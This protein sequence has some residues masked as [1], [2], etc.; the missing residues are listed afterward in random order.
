MLSAIDPAFDTGGST[1]LPAPA[2]GDIG[3]ALLL[4]QS[5][6]DLIVVR[7]EQKDTQIFNEP[8]ASSAEPTISRFTPDGALDPTFGDN[9]SVTLSYDGFEVTA[10][11]VDAQDRIVLGSSGSLIR[12]SPNGTPDD[13]FGPDGILSLPEPPYVLYSFTAVLPVQLAA[14]SDGTLLAEVET[15][16]GDG[17]FATQLIEIPAGGASSSGTRLLLTTPTPISNFT[18]LPDGSVLTATAGDDGNSPIALNDLNLN[19][20]PVTS[21]G[22]GGTAAVGIADDAVP[23]LVPEPDGD[24]LM[25]SSDTSASITNLAASNTFHLVRLTPAGNLDPAFDGGGVLSFTAHAAAL[26]V[27]SD[28]RVL[29]ATSGSGTSTDTTLAVTLHAFTSTGTPDPGVGGGTGSYSTLCGAGDVLGGVLLTAT[30]Q[31]VLLLGETNS[32]NGGYPNFSP[33]VTQA[34]TLV[35]LLA[36]GATP[37]AVPPTFTFNG[38]SPPAWGAPDL[39]FRVTYTASTA[40]S[41]ASVLHTTLSTAYLDPE[42][43]VPISASSATDAPSITVTYAVRTITGTWDTQDNGTYYITYAGGADSVADVDGNVLAMPDV[44][45]VSGEVGVLKLHAPKPKPLPVSDGGS[46]A[47]GS[48]G[49]VTGINDGGDLPPVYEADGGVLAFNDGIAW[50]AAPTLGPITTTIGA[51]FTQPDYSL[52]GQVAGSTFLTPGSRSSVLVTFTNTA[53]RYYHA[54]SVAVWLTL[55]SPAGPSITDSQ[56]VVYRLSVN[57]PVGKS[58]R[59]RIPFRLPKTLAAGSRYLLEAQA[60]LEHQ[61]FTGSTDVVS[62]PITV[63]AAGTVTVGRSATAQRR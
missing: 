1:T 61:Y 10:A 43:A 51:Q 7:S 23:Q 58:H 17:S 22:T 40:I 3:S 29:V 44:D 28:G 47:S 53:Q 59:L 5:N 30:D 42:P 37:N 8:F 33:T 13:T 27:G 56:L 26:A 31:P 49:S 4:H 9:G 63:A 25:L 46:G 6:G 15:Y 41:L 36:A 14:E 20:M 54:G 18:V 24:V 57:L 45:G 19:G 32:T 62:L 34:P 60:N 2:A 52:V 50:T 11:T 16:G 35:R 55:A 12:L 21:Y 48:E 38:G 39:T